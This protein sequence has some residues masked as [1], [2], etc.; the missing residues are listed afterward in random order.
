M[1]AKHCKLLSL[2]LGVYFFYACKVK[3]IN[4]NA[5]SIHQYLP[6]WVSDSFYTHPNNILTEEKVVLGRHLFYDRRLSINNTKACASCHAQQ[7]SFTD[8]YTKSIGAFGD[9]HLR[10]A[11]P[12][13]NIIFEKMLTA[14]DSS[15]HYPEQQMAGPMFNQHPVEMGWQGKEELILQRLRTDKLYKR[16]F[17]SAY[18]QEPN[19]YTTQ[20]VKWA[21]ASFVKTIISLTAPYD[22]YLYRKDTLALNTAQKKGMALFFSNKLNCVNCHNGINFSSASYFNMSLT[23][24]IIDSG[25]YRS[26]HNTNDIGKFKTPTLRNLAFTAPYLHD[27]TAE[28]LEKVIEKHENV[29][30]EQGTI[31]KSGLVKAFKLTSQQRLDLVAF[32]LSLSDSSVLTNPNYANPFSSDETR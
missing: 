31:Q 14:A 25:L 3:P 10:N 13:I 26:T 12:L 17:A 5:I 15:I 18:P 28:T 9:L 20:N 32:L 7:F 4:E 23:P 2:F 22:N 1:L 16:L 24:V 29:F 27:G 19:P 21:I 11:K 8:G 6:K 30:S